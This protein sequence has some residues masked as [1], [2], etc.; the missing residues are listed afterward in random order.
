MEGPMGPRTRPE[1]MGLDEIIL[2]IIL[3]PFLGGLLIEVIS[4]GG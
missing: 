4:D 2:N 3:T 1:K